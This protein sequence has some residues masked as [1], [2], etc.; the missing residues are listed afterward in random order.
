MSVSLRDMRMV[1]ISVA[2][3]ATLLAGCGGGG[4]DLSSLAG[5]APTSIDSRPSADASQLGS[6]SSR[7]GQSS[8]EDFGA[9]TINS[10]SFLGTFG[11]FSQVVG[12][13]A[14]ADY[15][16]TSVRMDIAIPQTDFRM[17]SLDLGHDVNRMGVAMNGPFLVGALACVKGLA[18][19]NVVEG[20]TEVQWFSDA[21][22]QLPVNSLPGVPVAGIE[23]FGNFEP[24]NPTIYFTLDASVVPRPD[25]MSLC[26]LGAGNAWECVP[27]IN[28]LDGM[29]HVLSSSVHGEGRYLLVELPQIAD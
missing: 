22:P 9:T 28:R 12:Y 6:V 16:D 11:G 1:G 3:A 2:V 29:S 24:G 26:K 5:G 17:D 14:S 27:A 18:R 13:L 21:L 25:D 19:V 20:Q 15:F 10:G 7:C 4:D 8:F 23:L